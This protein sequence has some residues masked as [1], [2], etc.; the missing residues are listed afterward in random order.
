M[1]F[2]AQLLRWLDTSMETPTLY[3]WFHIMWLVITAAIAVFLCLWQKRSENSQHR[4]VLLW[5]SIIVII[6]EVYKQINFSFSY[7]G[8]ISFDYAWYAFPFQFCSTPMFIGLLAG[9]TKPGKFHDALCAYLATFALFAGACVM[10]YPGDVFISTIGINIQTMVCH[11]SMIFIGI[12]LLA[13]DYVKISH[14]TILKAIP[15]FAVCVVMAV[16]MNEIASATGLLQT[17]T[18]NMFYVSRH[19][20]PH[21]PVYSLV[22]P[23]LPFPLALAVYIIGFSLA[24]YIILLI[25]MGIKKVCVKR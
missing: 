22:Q 3:G 10:F 14:K 20:D 9:L 18:F 15:V 11:G 1:N 23:L 25:A 16:A 17:D 24:A 19:C 6:L 5:I 21:L 13:T 7:E 12:Y 8:G 4:K 2:F